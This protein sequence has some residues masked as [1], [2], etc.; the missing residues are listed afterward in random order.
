MADSPEFLDQ[1]LGEEVCFLMLLVSMYPNESKLSTTYWFVCQISAGFGLWWS[2][3][4]RS[5][6][7]WDISPAGPA[8]RFHALIP[9]TYFPF[10][11]QD[12]E[13]EIHQQ[14]ETDTRYLHLWMISA[15]I[16]CNPPIVYTYFAV[17]YQAK[18]RSRQLSWQRRTGT[19]PHELTS[20]RNWGGYYRFRCM[21]ASS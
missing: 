2:G 7:I 12:Q 8:S 18:W 3:P 14:W 21:L 17:S 9:H 1:E 19:R 5:G 11:H 16:P 6:E 10:H 15:W 4:S 13:T 20:S